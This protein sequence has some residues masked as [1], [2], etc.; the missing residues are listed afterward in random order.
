M[1]PLLFRLDR[2]KKTP[3]PEQIRQGISTAI[4]MG[5]L[6][7]GARLPS[8]RDL[9]AQL[10]VSR[11]T[12]RSAYEKLINAQ[13]IVSGS[14]GTRVAERLAPRLQAELP[15]E[16]GSFLGMYRTHN[17]GPAAFRLGIPAH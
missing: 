6:A 10:G 13:L 7:P 8:G 5:V 3:L 11:G 4:E 12:V 17:S 9:A 16:P 14:S 15:A 2:S 1:K